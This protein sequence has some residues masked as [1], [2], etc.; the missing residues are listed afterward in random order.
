MKTI[1]GKFRLTKEQ[2]EIYDSIKNEKYKKLY[3]E[4]AQKY[5]KWEH[6]PEGVSYELSGAM[7]VTSDDLRAIVAEVL[8][9]VPDDVR[10]FV[11]WNCYFSSIECRAVFRDHTGK[12]EADLLYWHIFLYE[13]YDDKD[14]Y[15]SVIAHLIANAYLGHNKKNCFMPPKVKEAL[16]YEREA[17]ELVKKW[18]FV[19]SGAKVDEQLL[20]SEKQKKRKRT[21][22][23]SK[24]KS[25]KKRKSEKK[26]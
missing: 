7:C 15:Q 10:D 1:A 5:W 12:K 6:R 14:D 26:K 11:Y 21:S 8:L 18:G 25:K 13:D 23:K 16:K 17:C 2:K 3:I 9:K 20:K 24:R 19:G 22:K 4:Q